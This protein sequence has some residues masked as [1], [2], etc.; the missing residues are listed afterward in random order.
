MYG[1]VLANVCLL[2]NQGCLC[3][4]YDHLNIRVHARSIVQF[5]LS[6]M[7]KLIFDL[8]MTYLFSNIR[9]VF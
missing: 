1:H 4:E 8:H 6:E 2:I 3:H 9:V 5:V 7:F